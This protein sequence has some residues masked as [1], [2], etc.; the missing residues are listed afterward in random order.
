MYVCAFW[1]MRL[2]V[3]LCTYSKKLNRYV[4]PSL[5]CLSPF[6]CISPLPC[7]PLS[8]NWFLPRWIEWLKCLP[9]I[10]GWKKDGKDVPWRSAANEEKFHMIVQNNFF[11][12]KKF[13]FPHDNEDWCEASFFFFAINSISQVSLFSRQVMTKRRSLYLTREIV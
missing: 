4:R 5:R 12:S 10:D 9:P 2:Y 6:L 8:P 11:N 13:L 1:T 3:I 7:C